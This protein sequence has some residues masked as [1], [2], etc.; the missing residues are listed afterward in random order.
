VMDYV[1]ILVCDVMLVEEP[2]NLELV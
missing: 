1:W 2:K